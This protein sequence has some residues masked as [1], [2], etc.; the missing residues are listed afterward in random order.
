MLTPGIWQN[1]QTL[2]SEVLSEDGL[3]LIAKSDVINTAKVNQSVAAVAKVSALEFISNKKLSEE[4][5]GPWSLI[6]V[7]DDV[8]QL[9]QA[10]QSLE[11]QLTATVMAD[12]EEL[13]QYTV[14]LDT[15]TAITGRVILNGVPTGVEVC[16]AMQHGGP[17]PAAS[18]SRFT[19]VGTGAVYRFVRPVAW[20]DWED[21]LLPPELQ[22][23]NPLNIWRQ[24]NN[25][26]TKA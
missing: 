20:Q 5:F 22:A 14:L 15:L 17:F 6:V 9:E 16:A 12:R 19:S 18:D 3:E 10:I 11:G 7:A 4:I 25:N 24:V 1:Y 23:S 13:P 8:A 2:S 26:W 21:S